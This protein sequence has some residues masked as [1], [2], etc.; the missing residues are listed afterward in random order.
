MWQLFLCSH[1]TKQIAPGR[2]MRQ[3]FFCSPH[4]LFNRFPTNQSAAHLNLNFLCVGNVFHL[5]HVRA[6]RHSVVTWS[7]SVFSNKTQSDLFSAP[8]RLSEHTLHAWPNTLHASPN[9]LHASP[10]T[11]H[12]WPNTLHASPNTL[13]AW[14][15]TLHASTSRFTEHTSRLSEHTLRLT[16][17][18]IP[19]F[20]SLNRFQIHPIRVQLLI[21][22]FL[23]LWFKS[24]QSEHSSF[25]SVPISISL[26]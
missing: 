26:C 8:S 21:W 7:P 4:L 9:T 3:L 17:Q 19:L 18:A 1:L 16:K 13:H 6:W 23:C 24:D 25:V 22:I 2:L 20:S 14:P 5:Y 10:N 15:N 11:L 12:A